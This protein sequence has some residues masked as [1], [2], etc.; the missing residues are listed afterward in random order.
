MSK[1]VNISQDKPQAKRP[2]GFRLA[3]SNPEPAISP[4]SSLFV[5]VNATRNTENQ[6]GTL[7]TGS[8]VIPRSSDA[9]AALEPVSESPNLNEPQNDDHMEDIEPT[10]AVHD[11]TNPKPK[12]KRN[13]TNVV[14]NV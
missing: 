3:R 13:T 7:A 4:S 12:R 10:L 2:W 5:T 14:R 8:R 6:R 9:E 1:R 11:D